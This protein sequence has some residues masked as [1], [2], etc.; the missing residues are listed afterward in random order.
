MLKNISD[1]A[2]REKDNF[3][4]FLVSGLTQLSFILKSTIFRLLDVK[5]RFFTSQLLVKHLIPIYRTS[6]LNAN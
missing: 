5:R 6:E 2:H 3:A 4:E 1:L